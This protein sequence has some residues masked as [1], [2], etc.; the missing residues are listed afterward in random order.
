VRDPAERDDGAELR[1]FRNRLAEKITAGRDFLRCRLVL[2]RHAA[3]RV[4]DPAIEEREAVVRP[5][6]IGSLREAEILQRG[7][8]K[9]AGIIP[10]EGPAGAI[11]PA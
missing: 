9:I 7:V 6:F 3:H 5:R 8:E 1:H 10:R 4:S 11:G 2:G